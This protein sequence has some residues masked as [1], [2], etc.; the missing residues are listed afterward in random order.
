MS[1]GAAAPAS[2]AQEL[3]GSGH[4]AEADLSSALSLANIRQTLIRLEDTI[5]FSLIERAQFARNEPVYQPDAIPVP[6]FRPDGRRYSLLEYLLRETEQVRLAAAAGGSIMG[7]YRGQ[8]DSARSELQLC[9]TGGTCSGRSVAGRLVLPAQL[10]VLPMLRGLSLTLRHLLLL[11]PASYRRCTAE[12]GGTP[13]LMSTLSSPRSC[14]PWC[15]H[16]SLTNRWVVCP[17]GR[18]QCV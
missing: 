14:P 4:A 3:A 13:A 15:C 5:I 17:A 8:R 7:R 6:G 2:S 9:A 16:P 18:G 10:L 12:F 11:L 1:A